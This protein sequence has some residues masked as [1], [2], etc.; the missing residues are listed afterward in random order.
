MSSLLPGLAGVVA[1]ID[2]D[3]V[4]DPDEVFREDNF[5]SVVSL[6]D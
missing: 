2:L 1:G 6:P 5:V 4:L 3:R